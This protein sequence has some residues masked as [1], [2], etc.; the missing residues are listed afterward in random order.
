MAWQTM[1]VTYK[2]YLKVQV[3]D[4]HSVSNLEISGRTMK[5]NGVWEYHR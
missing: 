1:R 3:Y 2:G 4:A 5:L